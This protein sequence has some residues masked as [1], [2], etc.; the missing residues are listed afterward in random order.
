MAV[1]DN[2]EWQMTLVRSRDSMEQRFRFRNIRIEDGK[3]TAGD[4]YDDTGTTRLSALRG[5]CGPALAADLVTT[6]SFEFS[7]PK[8]AGRVGIFLAGYGFMPATSQRA[9]FR[10]NFRAYTPDANTPGNGAGPPPI[11]VVFDAGD[12]GTG[13]GMQT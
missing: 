12:T 11:V 13:S 4:V 8:I 2:Y 10:G 1:C 6:V 3:I 5:T 9:L 7:L